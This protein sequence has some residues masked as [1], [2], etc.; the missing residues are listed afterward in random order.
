[1]NTDL[2][3]QAVKELAGVAIGHLK[4]SMGCFCFPPESL[5]PKPTYARGSGCQGAET[6]LSRDF[7]P[8]AP[9][10]GGRRKEVRF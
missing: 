10:G 6:L 3:R 4:T 9:A 2:K 7:K 1:M 8:K 5:R